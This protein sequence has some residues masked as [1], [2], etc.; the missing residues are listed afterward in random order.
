MMN[1]M[2]KDSDLIKIVEE[3]G[4]PENK[5]QELLSSYKDYFSKA[6]KL[7]E[8]ARSIKVTSID[9]VGIMLEARECRLKL[10]EVRLDVENTRK[11]LKEQSLR[12]SKAIDGAANIIKA[13]IVPVEEYLEE[14]EKFV[15]IVEE[16]KKKIKV[17]NRTL[18]LSNYAVDD[19]SILQTLGDM[20]EEAYKNIL[21]AYKKSYEAEQEALEKAEKDREALEKAKLKDQERIRLENIQ[22][23]KEAEEREIEI[24]KEKELLDVLL[25][26]EAEEREKIEKELKQRKDAEDIEKARVLAQ[27]RAEE[28]I[29]KDLLLAPDKDKLINLSSVL[30]KIEMPRVS[31]KEM[32]ILVDEVEK[33]LR[34]IAKFIVDELKS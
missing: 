16:E 4:L 21:G 5:T 15:E 23:K 26:K 11:S 33:R 31:N 19:V 8:G 29:K 12:E 24:N 22:L 9:Q 27:K 32:G 17:A 1:E 13:L 2:N 6:D 7:V 3:S 25:K 14:Q 20:S 18:E 10:R 30:L 34:E 28:E